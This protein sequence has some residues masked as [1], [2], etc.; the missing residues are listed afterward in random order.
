M[1]AI[2]I[3]NMIVGG[4]F[5]WFINSWPLM[6][7]ASLAYGVVATLVDIAMPDKRTTT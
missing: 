7:A 3:N 6:I 1:R 2:H 5:G 4:F